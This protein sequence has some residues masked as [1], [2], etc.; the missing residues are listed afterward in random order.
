M[1]SNLYSNDADSISDHCSIL[2]DL[3]YHVAIKLGTNK[4]QSK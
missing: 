4:G 1:G 2:Q 3:R